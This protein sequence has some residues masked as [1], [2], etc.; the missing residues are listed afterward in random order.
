MGVLGI[1]FLVIFVI[2]ALIL[3]F[4][5]VIQSENTQGLGGIFGGSSDT[6]FGSRSGNILTKITYT[7]AGV[8]LVLTFVLA[9]INRTPEDDAMLQGANGQPGEEWWTQQPAAEQE[10]QTD[11]EVPGELDLDEPLGEPLE[12]PGEDLFLDD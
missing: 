1:I 8:F 11:E 3:I 10:E 2:I 4:L 6:A 5:V 7:V 9:F 12:Q